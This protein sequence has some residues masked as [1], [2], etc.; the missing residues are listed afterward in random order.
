MGVAIYIHENL[1]LSEKHWST[2][3][4]KQ[5]PQRYQEK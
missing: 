3:K 4:Q 1:I 5:Q 2:Q